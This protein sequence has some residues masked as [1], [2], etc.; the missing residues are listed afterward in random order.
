MAKIRFNTDKRT[1]NKCGLL[2]D[3]KTR[4]RYSVEDCARLWGCCERTAA[5]LLN[6][7]PERLRIEQI[8]K[9][10]LSEDE[11]VRLTK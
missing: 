4:N 2:A 9:M 10:K 7:Y 1:A 5:D 6:K 3:W 8:R 11:R